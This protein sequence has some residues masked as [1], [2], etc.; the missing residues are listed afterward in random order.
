[1]TTNKEFQ[2]LTTIGNTIIAGQMK[3]YFIQKIMVKLGKNL[4]INMIILCV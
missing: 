3:D 1:M 2:C 4:I